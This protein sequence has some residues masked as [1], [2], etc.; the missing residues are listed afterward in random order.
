MRREDHEFW[1]IEKTTDKVKALRKRE[2]KAQV[3]HGRI[4]LLSGR[5]S[6]ATEMERKRQRVDIDVNV[7]FDGFCFLLGLASS[8]I[9]YKERGR[10]VL[11]RERRKTVV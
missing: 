2:R 7:S 1:E 3:L 8:S 4:S 10:W 11:G 5:E 9:S 6:S